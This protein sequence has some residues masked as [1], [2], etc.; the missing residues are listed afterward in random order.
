MAEEIKLEKVEHFNLIAFLISMISLNDIPVIFSFLSVK[1]DTFVFKDCR[2]TVIKFHTKSDVIQKF[3]HFKEHRQILE[4]K[5][6]LFGGVLC[7][8]GISEKIEI[9]VLAKLGKW[10]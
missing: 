2:Y 8:L 9:G 6:F 7:L 5:I 1:I 3:N 4:N 10:K